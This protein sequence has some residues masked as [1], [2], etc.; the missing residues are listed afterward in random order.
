MDCLRVALSVIDY[1]TSWRIPPG[2]FSLAFLVEH[3]PDPDRIYTGT[4]SCHLD[5][6]Q[7]GLDHG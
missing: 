3:S 5:H 2:G 6:R 4:G 1:S 7:R